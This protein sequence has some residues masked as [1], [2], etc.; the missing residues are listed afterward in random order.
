MQGLCTNSIWDIFPYMQ[1]PPGITSRAD[2]TLSAALRVIAPLVTLLL[3]EGVTYGHFATA[4]KNTFL[5]AAPDVL[6]S[7]SARITDSSISTLTGVHRKDV[8]AWRTDGE[9][10]SQTRTLSVAMAVFT[11]WMNDPAYRDRRGRPRVLDRQGSVGSF[12]SLAAAVSNDVHSHT[13]LQELMRL[14]VVRRVEPRA[15]GSGDRVELC[16]DAFVPSKS[17]ADMLQL[18]S[19]NVGDHLAAAVHNVVTTE[20][21][22]LEQSMFADELT[23]KSAAAIGALAREIW[24]KAV[25]DLVRQA[26]AASAQ[27]AQRR[28]AHQRVRVGMYFYRAPQGEADERV[29]KQL[30][31]GA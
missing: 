17:A 13:L 5:D 29:R 24:E 30:D 10:P 3:R 12:E 21:P 2:L 15:P 14:G 25:R 9:A 8:R 26:A 1:N 11:R 7:S 19:D 6:Q 23:P 22:M 28:D 18:L 16:V 27:D 4:L 31:S 20:A